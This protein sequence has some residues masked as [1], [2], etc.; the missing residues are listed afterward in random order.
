VVEEYQIFF[1]TQ[2]QDESQWAEVGT[3]N[4][5]TLEFTHSGL[6]VTDDA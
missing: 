6:S 5:N 4:L 3:T 1:K 2:S